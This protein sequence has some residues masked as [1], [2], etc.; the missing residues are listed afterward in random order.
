[1]AGECPRCG[2]LAWDNCPTCFG[3]GICPSCRGSGHWR[4]G[5]DREVVVGPD[6]KA[7]IC[8]DCAMF[9]LGGGAGVVT[10]GAVAEDEPIYQVGPVEPLP[11]GGGGGFSTLGIVKLF[12]A[13]EAAE[14]ARKR[15]AG[16]PVHG[17]PVWQD[18]ADALEAEWL[19]ALRRRLADRN[20]S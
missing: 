8:P 11:P 9:R 7:W 20:S 16:L 4:T 12:A 17:N 5:E 2:H 13:R 1:M 6:G 15:R 3:S 10:I 19:A 18:A 14:D